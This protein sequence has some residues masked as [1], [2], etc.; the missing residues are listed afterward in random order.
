[1][2]KRRLIFFI[3]LPIFIII[4]VVALTRILLI[5]RDNLIAEREYETLRQYA[6]SVEVD[7]EPDNDYYDDEYEQQPESGELLPNSTQELLY[8]NDEYI[9]WIRITGTNI[10][11][12]MVQAENNFKYLRRTFTGESSQSGTLFMDFRIRD[13]DDP[14][15]I[16]YGHNMDNG[17]M[18]AELERFKDMDF[19][20]L[21]NEIQIFT[22]N[23]EVLIYTIF[24]SMVANVED[25]VFTLFGADR[26]TV[27]DFLSTIDA[28]HGAEH[29]LVLS[30]CIGDND[31]ERLLVLAIR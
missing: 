22:V 16:I 14:F 10:D 12:P 13:F 24:H 8:I 27:T 23:D 29:L 11:Y 31:D 5:Y 30:T 19:L 2:N 17:T 4:C 21:N 26:Q 15:A 25:I 9:G 18:F 20:A 6:P 7:V 3:L 28:P 1:M